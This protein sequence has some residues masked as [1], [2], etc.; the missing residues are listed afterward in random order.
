[1]VFTIEQELQKLSPEIAENLVQ[2]LRNLPTD[3]LEAVVDGIFIASSFFDALGFSLQERIPSFNTGSGN[4]D[5]ALRNNTVND[6]F[7]QTL[8]NPHVLVELKART[9]NLAYGT[10]SYKSTVKQL[11][12]YLLASNCKSAQWG[13]ITNSK[14]IQLF[15]KHGKV[16][17]PATPCLE[18][19]PENIGEITY[20]IRKKIE[21]T[22]R[23]LTVAVYNNKGG[24]GKTTAVINIAATLTRHNKKVLVVDFD[25]NQRDLTDSLDIKSGEATLYD[26]LQDKKNLI[27][28]KQVISPYTKTFKGGKTLSFDVI[29]VDNKLA[30]ANEDNLRNEFSFYSFRRKLESLK[31]DYDYI[32]I[33]A[34]PNWRFFSISAVYAA[35]VVLIPTKHNNI[36]SLQNAAISIQQYIPEIQKVRQEKTQGLEWG[37]IALP[38]FFNGEN[39]TDAARVRAKNAIN[40]IINKVKKENQFVLISYFYPN[41]NTGKNTKIFELPNNAHIACSA[42]DKIPAVYKSKVAY[43]YYSQL[44]KE[45]FLQ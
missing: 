26:C 16:I 25:P 28:L 45:Y 29:P 14:H 18:I 31:S 42:F 36:R 35:D 2:A 15:R 4:V 20:Q 44:A 27:S 3:A 33:D 40:V 41:Y 32:L 19:T 1:M 12:G 11:K 17:F 34:P 10:P 23:A 38:I 30:Q 24:V 43:D 21:H 7:L 8:V 5:Y 39:I 6:N 22:P 37:A 9:V 13:I